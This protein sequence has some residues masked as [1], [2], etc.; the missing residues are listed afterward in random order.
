MDTTPPEIINCPDDIENGIELGF[1]TKEIF[2]ID[3]MA[4]DISGSVSLV[5]QSHFSGSSFVTGKTKVQYIFGDSAGNEA[6]CQFYVSLTPGKGV[7]HTTV[8]HINSWK[9]ATNVNLLQDGLQL[10]DK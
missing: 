4:S 2:W 9:L 10:N 5:S 7:N 1:T 8:E 3:P 6:V